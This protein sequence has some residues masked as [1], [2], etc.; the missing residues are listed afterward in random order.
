MQRLH[1]LHQIFDVKK[2]VNINCAYII[3][4]YPVKLYAKNVK[5][6]KLIDWQKCQ[7]YECT[8]VYSCSKFI[9]V[10]EN[11]SWPKVKSLPENHAQCSFDAIKQSG[12]ISLNLQAQSSSAVGGFTVR[13]YLTRNTK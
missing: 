13:S 7:E 11:R 3:Y 4:V 8:S 12:Q 10:Y 6:E 9:F 2:H 1:V 5:F